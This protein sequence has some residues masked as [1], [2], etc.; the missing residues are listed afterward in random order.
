MASY[1]LPYIA[2]AG[3]LP[4][5]L[6]TVDD[7][8]SAE[9]ILSD[10]TGRKV[11]GVGIHFVVKYGIQ[12][13]PLEGQTMLFLA[14]ST[15]VPIPQVYAIFQTEQNI[16]Y[17]VMERIQ[18]SSLD[19]EWPHMDS[20]SKKAVTS[21]LQSI[22]GEMRKLP[23]PGGY[24]SVG[25]Q[26]LPDNLFWTDNPANPYSG[27][28]NAEADLNNALILKYKE[29]G[30]SRYKTSYYTRTFAEVFEGHKP[31]FSH[32]DFQ[33][34]NILV[35]NPAAQTDS[36]H[37]ADI[38]HSELVIIDWEFAGWYPSYWEYARAIFACGRWDD[39]WSDWVDEM[40][41]PYRNEYAWL[42]ILI[43][44]MWS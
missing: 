14:Q 21:Q 19:A 10:T 9:E 24:C 8:G 4:A 44:E 18:G 22:L 3:I 7:I 40:L 34:K 5:T 37:Q 41:E 31:T 26:G 38:A 33:R 43:R 29:Q 28:F 12:V 1:G 17:I 32:A 42:G 2:D 36:L 39:D 16:T 6:P 11:V 30:L 23:S 27:P 13:D 35:R 20:T 15:L 25:R